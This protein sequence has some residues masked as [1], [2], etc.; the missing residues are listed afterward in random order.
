[1]AEY[2]K[3]FTNKG[4]VLLFI[5][6]HSVSNRIKALKL[7]RWY[8]SF[9]HVIHGLFLYKFDTLASW[10]PIASLF[11]LP[12]FQKQDI[13]LLQNIHRIV[14]RLKSEEIFEI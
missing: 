8:S 10:R 13:I 3:R 5:D 9:L 14:L 11:P 1:M 2:V 7:V 6:F 4:L 12:I